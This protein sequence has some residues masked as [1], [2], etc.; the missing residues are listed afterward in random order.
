[1]NSIVLSWEHKFHPSS[2]LS[3]LEI[4]AVR[5]NGEMAELLLQYGADLN[6]KAGPLTYSVIN[7]SHFLGAR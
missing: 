6:F 2:G 1:M 4:V 7:L 5:G 3:A